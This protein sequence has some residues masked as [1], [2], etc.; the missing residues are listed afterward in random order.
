MIEKNYEV[1]KIFL[2]AIKQKS[3]FKDFDPESEL[4]KMI[5]LN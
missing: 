5:K 2:A 3:K 4:K 1:Q